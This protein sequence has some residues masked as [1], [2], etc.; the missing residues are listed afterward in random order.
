MVMNLYKVKS[1]TPLTGALGGYR[2]VWISED[3]TDEFITFEKQIPTSPQR[4]PRG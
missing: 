4:Y 3:G 1:A 2:V